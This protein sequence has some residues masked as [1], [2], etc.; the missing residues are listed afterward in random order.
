[1]NLQTRKINFI[2]EFL[3]LSNEEIIDKLENLL[4]KERKIK[5]EQGLKPMSTTDLNKIIDSAEKDSEA[6]KVTEARSLKKV[7]KGWK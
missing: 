7:I 5:F 3:R 2:Q 6:G 1:M 4:Q